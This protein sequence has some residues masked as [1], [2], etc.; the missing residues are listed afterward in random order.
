MHNI[1]ADFDALTRILPLGTVIAVEDT[2]YQHSCTWSDLDH[3]L[4]FIGSVYSKVNRWKHLLRTNPRVYA[5]GDALGTW[6]SYVPMAQELE[7]DPRVRKVYY[8]YQLPLAAIIRRAR[9]S[10]LRVVPERVGQAL[11]SMG[12]TQADA[13]T[14]AQAHCGWPI[15]L[16]SAAQVS[17]ELYTVER[18]HL[19]DI[20]GR[21]RR[22]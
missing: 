6:D 7:R 18:V 4:D 20:T 12:Q 1:E 17:H 13:E 21:P 16:G 5:G 10:G 2:M 11:A 22:L 14:A 3:D 8:E 15:N 19:N 9:A